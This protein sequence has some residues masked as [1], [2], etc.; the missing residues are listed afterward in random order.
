MEQLCLSPDKPIHPPDGQD[1]ARRGIYPL[2]LLPDSS[3][4]I[5]ATTDIPSEN[6]SEQNSVDDG[7]HHPAAVTGKVK[8]DPKLLRFGAITRLV[9]QEQ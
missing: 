7:P 9:V 8:V 4:C 1:A 5:W 6:L 3:G 2:K